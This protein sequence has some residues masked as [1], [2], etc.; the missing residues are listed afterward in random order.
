MNTKIIARIVSNILIPPFFFLICIFHISLYP[1]ITIFEMILVVVFSILVGLI[2]P[3]SFVL[4]SVKQKKITNID[5]ELKE[6]R[7][8]PY[9]L[10]IVL[11]TIAFLI[12]Y[13][14]GV[15]KSF[16]VF[17]LA[18]IVNLLIL[19]AV[20]TFWKISAHAQGAAISL[21]LM[22]HD[23]WITF[24]VILPLVL[25]VMWSRYELKVH[26]ISQIILGSIAGFTSTYFILQFVRG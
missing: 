20:N 15:D 18:Y 23:K 19:F 9:L 22:A 14:S 11:F 8:K 16:S 1:E 7:T 24:F 25:I 13:L 26:S 17:Y 12:L 3:V 4:Q 10:G 21:G 6:E 2:I 5:A